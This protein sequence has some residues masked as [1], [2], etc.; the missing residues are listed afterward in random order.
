MLVCRWNL[1]PCKRYPLSFFHS[2][3]SAAVIFLRNSLRLDLWGGSF[4]IVVV[5]TYPHPVSLSLPL[6]SH[7][8]R[9]A[10][11][12]KGRERGLLP[13]DSIA[14][15]LSVPIIVFNQESIYLW[16][17]NGHSWLQ[18]VEE[19]HLAKCNSY[20]VKSSISQLIRAFVKSSPLPPTAE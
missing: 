18:A 1:W 4:N 7:L 11:V 10:P 20:T 5:K 12:S 2:V 14:S 8:L 19:I 15:T 13:N 9:R 16:F 3:L 6:I 17:A